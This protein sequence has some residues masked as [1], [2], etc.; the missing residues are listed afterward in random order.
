VK[1][2]DT[3]LIAEAYSKIEVISEQRDSQFWYKW[4]ENYRNPSGYNDYKHYT[5]NADNS[6]KINGSVDL[7]EM[8]ITSLSEIPFKIKEVNGNFIVR[9]NNLTS[10]EGCPEIVTFRF[11]CSEN[12]L[13]SLEG[14]P[15][16]VIEQQY[17]S[18]N[19]YNCSKNINLTSLKGMPSSVGGEINADKCNLLSLEGMPDYC[20]CLKI[21]S[22][23]HLQ[24]LV[25]APQ[26]VKLYIDCSEC[27]LINL[28]GCP[29]EV[30]IIFCSLNKNLISLEGAP[31]KLKSISKDETQFHCFGCDKLK[32]LEFLPEADKYN[33]GFE[34]EKQLEE[35]KKQRKID[36]MAGEISDDPN[37]VFV[38]TFKDFSKF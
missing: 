20:G 8:G 1:D 7:S 33:L 26:K 6:I 4:L 27:D 30:R 11:D 21:N 5:K 35:I 23:R 28:I 3:N 29:Q 14:S 38:K 37:D 25:G 9:G 10:L 12:N 19:E 22:N 16:F 32:S 13:S 31:K 17:T 18:F 24:S 15:K 36:K 34:L 2:K